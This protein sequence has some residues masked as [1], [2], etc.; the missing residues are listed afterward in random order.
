M[1]GGANPGHFAGTWTK[2]LALRAWIPKALEEVPLA[3][4]LGC[5]LAGLALASLVW[6]MATPPL[7]EAAV[8][9]QPPPAAAKKTQ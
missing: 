1:A 2:E 5:A 9:A 6:Q 3:L 8:A 4:L 7:E